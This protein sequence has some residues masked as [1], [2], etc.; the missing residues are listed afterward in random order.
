MKEL[1][2]TEPVEGRH[3]SASLPLNVG[4]IEIR[5]R[6]IV[7]FHVAVHVHESHVSSLDRSE[8]HLLTTSEPV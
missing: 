8:G 4:G 1:E 6:R 7:F 3:V 5:R 2:S